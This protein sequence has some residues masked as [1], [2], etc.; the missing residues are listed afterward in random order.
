[1]EVTFANVISILA[2]V[3]A[4]A[5]IP[6][7]KILASRSFKSNDDAIKD[8]KKDLAELWDV[9]ENLDR[10]LLQV[11]NLDGFRLEMIDKFFDKKTFSRELELIQSAIESMHAQVLQVEKKIEAL[12]EKKK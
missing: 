8:I 9:Y 12:K 4:V 11:E 10:K 3:A 7:M 6:L 2:L 5:A 1:M